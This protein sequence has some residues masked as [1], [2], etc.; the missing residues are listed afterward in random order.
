MTRSHLCSV[1]TFSVVR[2][3][4]MEILMRMRFRYDKK[5]SAEKE[6]S[7]HVS[8][9]LCP[10]CEHAFRIKNKQNV[11]SLRSHNLHDRKTETQSKHTTTP[12]CQ[13]PR[14]GQHQDKMHP[15][16][17]QSPVSL[18]GEEPVFTCIINPP[19]RQPTWKGRHSPVVSASLRGNSMHNCEDV[20]RVYAECL[21]THSTD[22]ACKTAA[23]YFSLCMNSV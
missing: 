3:V 17:E 23:S 10:S 21:E 16:I 15:T 22:N 18:A 4:K 11:A 12:L 2:R 20:R 5:N 19:K 13:Q 9:S 1:D 8:R 14:Q 6:H 7:H